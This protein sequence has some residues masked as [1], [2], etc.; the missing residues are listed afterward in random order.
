MRDRPHITVRPRSTPPAVQ[1]CRDRGLP[2]EDPWLDVRLAAN[3]DEVLEQKKRLD[4]AVA[5]GQSSYRIFYENAA[6][7][8]VKKSCNDRIKYFMRLDREPCKPGIVF[9]KPSKPCK[10]R[11]VFDKPSPCKPDIVFDV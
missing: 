1:P 10:P 6:L 11:I 5:A 8:D 7:R 3:I 4:Q 9:D 2:W